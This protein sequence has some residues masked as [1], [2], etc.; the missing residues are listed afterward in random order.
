MQWEKPHDEESFEYFEIK[1]RNTKKEAKFNI[2]NIKHTVENEITLCNL[3][4]NTEYEVKGFIIRDGESNKIFDKVFRTKQSSI[5]DLIKLS[6]EVWREPKIYKLPCFVHELDKGNLRD[7]HISK[8]NMSIVCKYKI[9]FLAN[10]MYNDDYNCWLTNDYF[11]L[12]VQYL[13]PYAFL[14]YTPPQKWRLMN[15]RVVT[16]S[17]PD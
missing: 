9:L 12:V 5:P 15:R 8:L 6:V 13:R 11:V 4:G 7:C 17:S 3:E 16:W 14:F 2:K 10:K 1:Y